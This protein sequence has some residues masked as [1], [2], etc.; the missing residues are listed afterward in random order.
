MGVFQDP[1]TRFK[2]G[3]PGGPGR[4]RRLVWHSR[5]KPWVDLTR[6]GFDPDVAFRQWVA[7]IRAGHIGALRHLVEYLAN[8]PAADGDDQGDDLGHV[9]AIVATL[10]AVHQV[11]SASPIA[12]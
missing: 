1:S 2:A 4:P 12:D 9:D 6:P 11:R 8:Q 5:S 10:R 7:M 3:G